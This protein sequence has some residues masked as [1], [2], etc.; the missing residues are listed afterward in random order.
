MYSVWR[1]LSKDKE[2]HRVLISGNGSPGYFLYKTKG[3]NFTLYDG[4]TPAPGALDDKYGIQQGDHT[5]DRCVPTLKCG[6]GLNLCLSSCLS[7]RRKQFIQFE[8]RTDLCRLLLRI[9]LKTANLI[10]TG[11]NHFQKLS[12]IPLGDMPQCILGLP[13][14]SADQFKVCKKQTDSFVCTV[15]VVD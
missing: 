14:N 13:G 7:L 4:G 9:I 6:E 8:P 1:F 10:R 3:D 15:L 5:A 2:D 11:E 12:Y